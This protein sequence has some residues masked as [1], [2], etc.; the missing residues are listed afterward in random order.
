MIFTA[1]LLRRCPM[2]LPDL[3]LLSELG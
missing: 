2:P 3:L 1:R